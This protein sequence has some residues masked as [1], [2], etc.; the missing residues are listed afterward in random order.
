MCTTLRPTA[1]AAST[2][3]LGRLLW[4]LPGLLPAALLLTTLAAL[5]LLVTLIRHSFIPLNLER[6]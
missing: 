1:L 4:R 5:L 3:L 6:R 2:G